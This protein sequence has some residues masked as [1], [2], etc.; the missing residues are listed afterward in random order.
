VV[1][2]EFMS[3][4]IQEMTEDDLNTMLSYAGIAALMLGF[5]SLDAY[6]DFKYHAYEGLVRFGGSFCQALGRVLGASD[7]VNGIKVVK[8]WRSECEEHA[9]LHR[10]FMK[11]RDKK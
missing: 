5:P 10:L 6:E 4:E 2:G 8:T 7:M 11:T 3:I 1:F 9:E